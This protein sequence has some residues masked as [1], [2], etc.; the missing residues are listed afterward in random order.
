MR[1]IYPEHY[2]PEIQIVHEIDWLVLDFVLATYIRI[3]RRFQEAGIP[4]YVTPLGEHIPLQRRSH[5][6]WEAMEEW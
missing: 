1:G 2:E 4:I 5:D 6:I 3:N